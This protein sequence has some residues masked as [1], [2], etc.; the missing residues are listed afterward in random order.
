MDL[1]TVLRKAFKKGEETLLVDEQVIEF[2][3]G[4]EIID[5]LMFSQEKQD[6]SE[7]LGKLAALANSEDQHISFYIENY[8]EGFLDLQDFWA[9]N[10]RESL[11]MYFADLNFELVESLNRTRIALWWNSFIDILVHTGQ[12]D[13]VLDRFSKHASQCF[14][15][16][17]FNRA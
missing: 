9:E 2:G 6:I 5:V 7:N 15:L 12:S 4:F 14:D 17:Y 8:F 11:K 3:N 10:A 16:R 1:D 13:L